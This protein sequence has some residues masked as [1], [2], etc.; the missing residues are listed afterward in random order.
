MPGD[1]R[2]P[3]QSIPYHYDPRY[4]YYPNPFD[5]GVDGLDNSLQLIAEEILG[6]RLSPERVKSIKKSLDDV[7]FAARNWGDPAFK[8]KVVQLLKSTKKVVQAYYA[9]SK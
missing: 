9:R 7:G 1:L 2:D 8:K 3:E 4:D 5:P 6:Y